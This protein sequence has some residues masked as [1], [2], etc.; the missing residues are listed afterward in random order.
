[1]KHVSHEILV[2]AITLA[3]ILGRGPG[4]AAAELGF[5]PDNDGYKQVVVPFFRKHCAECHVGEKPEG[6]FSITK[7]E[8]GTDFANPV[9]RGKWREIVNVLNSHGM[10]PEDKPQP[11]ATEAAAVVDWITKQAV[12]AEVSKREQ[13]VVLRRL[14]RAE[15]K[16][17][18]RDL[19]GI[20]FDTSVFPQD[21][22]AGG[23]D[24]NGGALTMSPMQIEQ[25]LSAADQ[26][27]DQ[28]LVEGKQPDMIRWKFDPVPKSNDSNR[29]RLDPKNNPIV[30]G[31]NN[32]YE[33]D[34]VV[35]HH[36]SWDKNV[37]ARDFRVP[38]PGTYIVR[39]RV[40]GKRPSRDDVVKSAAA[41]LKKRQEEQNA[42]QPERAT[43]NQS[44]YDN[45]LKHFSVDPMYDYGPARLKLVVQLG[46]QPR[47]VAAFDV[48]GT[49]DNPQIVE[50]PVRFTTE[51]AG[52]TLS[53][54]YD[55][56]KVL[57]NFWLQGNDEFARP[58]A[59]IDW[60]ELEGPIYDA[61]PP[62]SHTKIL[63]DSP[64][65]SENLSDYVRAVLERFMSEAYRR[66]VT[67]EEVDE[68]FELYVANAKG[69]KSFVEKVKVP[70]T[71]VLTSPSFLYL[72]EAH[73]GNFTEPLTNH[74]LATRLSYFLWSSQPDAELRQLAD[75]DK[76]TNPKTRQEQVDRM[77]ADP[78]ADALVKNFA[79]QWLGLREV[80]ANPPAPDLYPQYDR[81]LEVS[82]VG[83]SEAYFKE[84]LQHD[85]DARQMIKSD[86]VTINERLGRF[87]G[88]PN[89]RGDSYQ[90]VSVPKGVARGGI[91]T[92]ASI[93]TTTSNGTRTSPVKRGT[94]ILK[95]LLGTDP[96][97]P[98]ANA[99][100]IS[101]KVP[102]ID[103]ATVRQR[104]EI[105]RQLTQCARC[106]NKIDPLGFALE[107]F[108]AAGDWREQE[109]FGYKGRVQQNDPKIDASSK[110]PDGTK[111][112]GVAGLQ[113]AMLKQED[114]FLK[115]LSTH[116]TTYALGRELGLADQPLIDG[117]VAAMK[118]NGTTVRSLVK[119][120][121]ASDAFAAK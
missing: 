46:S 70:L 87:Y 108:N 59:M 36:E 52:V 85:L 98:V 120:I 13:S 77:L 30:N 107:N 109:G 97:L 34:W 75:S 41:I 111:I 99:G 28:A 102:G 19:V 92:Q 44:Q 84:F 81:H 57:E 14:N 66:P 88:I 69:K 110:M 67:K 117:T 113:A 76:L 90:K 118:E 103:K 100:E 101:P 2:A 61:W 43:Q 106:H 116:L 82:I 45:N 112:V 18:V 26:I 114:L 51:S 78:K 119:A 65:K 7:K 20:D 83:E 33:G 79:G 11:D 38:Q 72:A 94:W 4:L 12:A 115:S 96:G 8:L 62:S 40:A 32:A 50:F 105:H 121:V 23:F 86:F 95:T 48:E 37:N 60:L 68:K 74:E 39:A 58:E 56:P 1:M 25:Y 10:P 55:I 21:P 9:Y 22:P 27:L 73:P 63:F 17:T 53:Y 31:G 89:V 29:V 54:A 35:V 64:L 49:P 93:L 42:K 5:Q 104:L 24:N 91:V 71:A 16:N 47:T 6:E 15:Y 80:G 3:V